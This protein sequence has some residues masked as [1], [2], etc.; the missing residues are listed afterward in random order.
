MIYTP[1]VSRPT[2]AGKDEIF[3]RF[4]QV[5]ARSLGAGRELTG[6]WPRNKQ[7]DLQLILNR[8]I[9]SP[10]MT[11]WLSQ[12]LGLVAML[13]QFD[14]VVAVPHMM[15][16]VMPEEMEQLL[17]PFG[18]AV[19]PRTPAQLIQASGCVRTA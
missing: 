2:G 15:G 13:H 10:G 3:G 8:W 18:G 12:R 17:R 6:G 4:P 1:A 5:L 7:Y 14:T 9:R 19:G 11:Q 16:Q